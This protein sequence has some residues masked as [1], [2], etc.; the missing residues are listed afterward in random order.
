MEVD[1]IWG[2]RREMEDK[3][4]GIDISCLLV[5]RSSTFILETRSV[6]IYSM[7]WTLA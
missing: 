2:R 1:T 7:T 4:S 6:S 3:S 5:C